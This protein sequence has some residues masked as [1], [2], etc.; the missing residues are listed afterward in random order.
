MLRSEKRRY[1]SGVREAGL[2]WRAPEPKTDFKGWRLVAGFVAV[3]PLL[4][5]GLYLIGMCNHAGSLSEWA[6]E[7]SMFQTPVDR[8]HFAGFAIFLNIG[9]P[10]VMYLC[11]ALVFLLITIAFITSFITASKGL[12][13]L[14]AVAWR[15]KLP[16]LRTRNKTPPIMDEFMQRHAR[17][18]VYGSVAIFILI[19]TVIIAALSIAGGR[20]R[21]RHEIEGFVEGKSPTIMLRLADSPGTPLKARLLECGAAFCAMLTSDGV[22]VMRHDQML[23]FI[24]RPLR[25]PAADSPGKPS[26]PVRATSAP[27]SS[28]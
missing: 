16:S 23:G 1:R 4:A 17:P 24:A 8:L 13:S 22:R 10:A 3:M 15:K 2:K 27:A 26:V 9:F 5:A 18:M 14:A 11:F 20:A 21:A 19:M 28:V 7:D 6:L 25:V 12:T